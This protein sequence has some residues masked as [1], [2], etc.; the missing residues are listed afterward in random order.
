MTAQQWAEQVRRRLGLGRLVALGGAQDGAWIAE[1]AAET[2]LRRAAAEVAG[3][4]LGRLRIALADP[5]EAVEPVV[6]PPP[7]ALPPGALRVAAELSATAA[8][9]L[10]ATASRLRATLTRAAEELGLAVAEVD[11]RVTGLLEEEQETAGAEPPRTGAVRPE[12]GPVPPTTRPVPPHAG[13]VPPDATAV[14]PGAGAVP[15]DAGGGVPSAEEAR[16]ARAALSV[17]GV[18][19][20]TGVLGRAVHI[21]EG[22]RQDAALP[23]RHVRLEVAVRADHRAVE[24]ARE[25]RAAVAQALEDGPTV[26]VLVTAVG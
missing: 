23:R 14:P 26:A 7:S 5:G 6:P 8:E 15:P 22:R 4:R 3:A 20:L 19:Y 17:A 11:L 16:V 21:E 13:A 24:V 18:A 1:G 2:V 12:A 25:V 9:P 10:P